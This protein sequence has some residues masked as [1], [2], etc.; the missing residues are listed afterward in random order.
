[1]KSRALGADIVLLSVTKFLSGNATVLGG[2]IVAPEALVEDIRWNTTEFVGS[3][4]PPL[5][6]LPLLR[7]RTQEEVQKAGDTAW[8]CRICGHVHVG[9]EAPEVCPY[10]FFPKSAFKA[11]KWEE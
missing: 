5:E 3:V 9:K 10:C 8:R 2:A 1:M 7:E 6:D 4:M 11:A